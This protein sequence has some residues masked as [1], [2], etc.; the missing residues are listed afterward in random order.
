MTNPDERP[1][2]GAQAAE[3]AFVRGG[4]AVEGS[5]AASIDAAGGGSSV[6]RCA[7]CEAARPAAGSFCPF[8]GQDNARGRLRL[9]DDLREAFESLANLDGKLV[10]TIGRLTVDPGGVA[11]DYVEGRR[12]RY[13][14]PVRYALGACALWWAV[15]ALRMPAIEADLARQVALRPR[16]AAEVDALRAMLKYGQAANL[17]FIPLLVP[18]LSLAFHG[19]RRTYAEHLCLLLYA[20]GHVFLFRAL[21]SASV[22]LAPPLAAVEAVDPFFFMGFVGY[23][24]HRFHRDPPRRVLLRT[25]FAVLL[26]LL[27]S[28]AL[29][30]LG[31]RLLT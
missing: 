14:S 22:A 15:I 8:C 19:F 4:A 29:T 10:R 3:P 16:L 28:S 13:V 23:A 1:I 7:N 5:L 12:I 26:V 6:A 20:C 25:A 18:A 21:L 31:K 2:D 24:V 17:L 9:R 30:L 11:R 27:L